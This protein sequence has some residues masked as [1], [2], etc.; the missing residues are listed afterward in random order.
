MAGDAVTVEL[1]ELEAVQETL[2]RAAAAPDGGLLAALAQA[3]ESATAE[4]ILAGGPAPDGAP[5]AP[6]RTPRGQPLLN[7]DGGLSDSLVGRAASGAAEWGSPLA[8]ARIHQRGGTILGAPLLAW[9]GPG[10]EM[11]FRRRAEI[12]ARP[13]LGIGEAERRMLLDAV[14]GWVEGHLAGGA[15]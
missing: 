9:P 12:P 14:E 5:W 4:R 10:G 6:R 15:R 3:G 11:V 13:Y 1:A 7:L 2:R 8:Y